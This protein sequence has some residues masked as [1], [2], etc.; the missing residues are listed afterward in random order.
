MIYGYGL[1]SD[2]VN[3]HPY[4][5]REGLRVIHVV[6]NAVT[7]ARECARLGLEFGER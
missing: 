7:R 5:G 2:A 4:V 6:L 3:I 1:G